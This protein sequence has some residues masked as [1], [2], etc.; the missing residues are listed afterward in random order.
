MNPV[1]LTRAEE[2]SE[3]KEGEAPK[4][5]VVAPPGVA[6]CRISVPPNGDDCPAAATC[7]IVW[8]DGDRTPACMDCAQRTAQMA[9]QGHHS[10]IRLERL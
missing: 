2:A 10:S 7:T 3:R 4:V 6:R 5:I 9:Q 1:G 8:P